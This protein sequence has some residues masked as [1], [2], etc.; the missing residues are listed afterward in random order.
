[1]FIVDPSIDITSHPNK[2]AFVKSEAEAYYT[3]DMFIVGALT[4]L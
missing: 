2:N 3:R 1:M 4:E